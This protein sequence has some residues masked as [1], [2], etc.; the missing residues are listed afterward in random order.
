MGQGPVPAPPEPETR[1]RPWLTVGAG[2]G[3]VGTTGGSVGVAGR[4]TGLLLLDQDVVRR[5]VRVAEDAHTRHALVVG[6]ERGQRREVTHVVPAEGAGDARD[7]TGGG[8]GL[9]DGVVDG[10]LEQAVFN[11]LRRTQT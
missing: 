7:P 1:P 11:N 5:E 3:P 4:G 9:G 8:R 6:Q 10:D 2:S